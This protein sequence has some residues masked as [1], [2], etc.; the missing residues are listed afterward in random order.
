MFPNFIVQAHSTW[1]ARIQ[2][3]RLLYVGTVS[4]YGIQ[5]S[6]YKFHWF[7]VVNKKWDWKGGLWRG[8]VATTGTQLRDSLIMNI[9]GLKFLPDDALRHTLSQVLHQKLRSVPPTAV[10]W[11]RLWNRWQFMVQPSVSQPLVGRSDRQ[12]KTPSNRPGS[13]G[14]HG[15]LKWKLAS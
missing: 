14:R 12:G 1:A 9:Q 2:Y 4:L 6:V 11:P 13:Y 7:F 8:H 5:L 15:L 10:R 3:Y